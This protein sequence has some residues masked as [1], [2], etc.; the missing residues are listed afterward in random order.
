MDSKEIN[1]RIKNLIEEK[2]KMTSY[3]FS[4]SIG[5]KRADNIY[6]IINEKVEIS[7]KNLLKILDKYPEYALF[8][9]TGN[10]DNNSGNVNT[11]Y[12]GGHNLNIQNSDYEK[13]IT[14]KGIELTKQAQADSKMY[15]QEINSLKAEI[16]RL[17]AIIKS[18]D[19]TISAKD[20]TI[21]ILTK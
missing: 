5:N 4:K 12:V 16:K 15:I 19:E 21:R 14:E 3:E 18:K 7:P 9:L 8:L 17:E 2:L 20:E 13:I 11:G 6:N 1:K 10:V